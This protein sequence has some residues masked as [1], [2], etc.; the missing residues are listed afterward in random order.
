MEEMNLTTG[1][2]LTDLH[3]LLYFFVYIFIGI[4]II[5]YI[6]KEEN[7]RLERKPLRDKIHIATQELYDNIDNN[8]L[9]SVI[10]G[11]MYIVIGIALYV[12]ITK[13]ASSIL[14]KH[15]LP[16]LLL[17]F[18]LR[19]ACIWLTELP[20]SMRHNERSYLNPVTIDHM[21]S[22]HTMFMIAFVTYINIFYPLHAPSI[23]FIIFY[24]FMLVVSR[25]HYSID[26]LVSLA[27]SFS[28]FGK[29]ISN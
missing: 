7:G 25:E 11:I 22:S 9:L 2:G 14:T 12:Y 10:D 1:K 15:F 16:A 6:D 4:C 29:Y 24:A 20:S 18:Y 19:I 21:F 3:Y 5:Q 23:L 13:D 26:V 17:M 28:V 8:L 27:L